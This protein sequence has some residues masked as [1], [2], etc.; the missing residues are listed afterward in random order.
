MTLF[1]RS[2]LFHSVVMLLFISRTDARA[3]QPASLTPQ[4]GDYI[5]RDFHFRS[6]E[7][8]AELR[9]HYRTFGKPA[10]DAQGRVTN[11]VLI[12]HGTGGSGR[13]FLQPQFAGVLFGPGQ[14]LDAGRYFIILPDGVGHGGSAKPSDGMRAHFPQYDYDDMVAAQHELVEEGLGVNHLRLVMGTSMGCMHSWVWLETYPDYMDA[15]MPLACLPV[16]IAGRN[17]IWRKMVMDGI[18]QDPEW[19]NGDYTT[20]PRAALQIALDFLLIAGSTPLPMQN[21]LPTRDAADK[22]LADFMAA[23]TAG[24]DAND[25]LY[26]VNASRHYDPSPRLEAITAPVMYVNSGDDFINPPELGIAEKEI[27]RVRNG[28]F[29]LIPASADTHGHGTH[30]WAALWQPYLKELLQQSAH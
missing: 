30:T 24:L 5:A 26:A 18:R 15:S 27:K 2:F 17:R 13:Q 4:E 11:A 8:L 28:R 23:R 29:V 25:F 21:S 20:Q 22:Y 19:K 16:Q 12:L 10:R 9:L 14:L 7:T 3:Q 1:K 6:G